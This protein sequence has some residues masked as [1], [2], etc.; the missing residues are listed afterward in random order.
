[1]IVRQFSG[2]ACEWHEKSF[3][4]SWKGKFD[5]FNTIIPMFKERYCHFTDTS[6]PLKY[7]VKQLGS[8]ESHTNTPKVITEVKGIIKEIKRAK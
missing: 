2:E 5:P 7:R 1:M 4:Q 3:S 8:Q 6:I